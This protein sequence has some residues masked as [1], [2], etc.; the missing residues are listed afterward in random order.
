MEEMEYSKQLLHW[1]ILYYDDLSNSQLMKAFTFVPIFKYFRSRKEKKIS[2]EKEICFIDYYLNSKSTS[3]I[4]AALI[5][6][7]CLH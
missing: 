4:F 2:A 7:A 6:C 5:P 1:L 3:F